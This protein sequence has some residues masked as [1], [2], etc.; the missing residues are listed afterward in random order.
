METVE[1]RSVADLSKSILNNIHKIPKNIDLVVGIPRS[2]M[3]PANLISLYLN[4]P[5]TDINSFL[6]GKIYACGDRGSFIKKTEI[7]NILIVDDSIA[8]G[9]AMRR[10]KSQL[11]NEKYN[12]IY[13]VVYAR[14]KS[15]NNVDLFCEILDGER[16]FEWNLFHHKTILGQSCVDIDGVLCRDPTPEENDDGEKYHRFLLTA[17]PK[18]IPTVKIKT[19][20]SCRLEKYRNET[21]A[22]LKK[23]GI[24]YDNLIMLN[25]PNAAERQKWNKYGDYKATEYKKPEYVLFIESSLN[26]AKRIKEVSGKTV[27]CIETM[28]IV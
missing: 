12:F 1:Y 26:E 25:L 2:G 9:F 23:Y 27:F 16:I 10:A 21:I 5:Y 15:K 8:H 6:E 28:N 7:K 18:F 24:E 14:T 17:V 3:L 11:K 19:L 22:W 4:K 20:I 13:F